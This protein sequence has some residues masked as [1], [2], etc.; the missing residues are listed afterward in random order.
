M[1]RKTGHA[2]VLHDGRVRIPAF[3]SL[4]TPTA[5]L[6]IAIYVAQH[7]RND[8]A[9]ILFQRAVAFA[10]VGKSVDHE[11]C[12][13]GKITRMQSNS[14]LCVHIN[15]LDANLAVRMKALGAPDGVS[16]R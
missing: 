16:D 6:P 10:F 13:V 9:R 1:A 5:S 7:Y 14:R 15:V 8:L 12:P 4:E 11:Y 3:E 2:S